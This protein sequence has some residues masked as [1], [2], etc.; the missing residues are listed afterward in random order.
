MTVEEE[1]DKPES[2]QVVT[3]ATRQVDIRVRDSDA[4]YILCICRRKICLSHRRRRQYLLSRADMLPRFGKTS[5][6]FT[7]SCKN[8]VTFAKVSNRLKQT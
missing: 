6:L 5:C 7:A 3:M 2:K 8:A 1:V 4:L